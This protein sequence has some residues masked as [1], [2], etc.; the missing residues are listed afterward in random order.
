MALSSVSRFRTVASD[1]CF[2]NNPNCVP[3]FNKT[4]LFIIERAYFPE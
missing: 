4:R 1:K 2:F 3:G